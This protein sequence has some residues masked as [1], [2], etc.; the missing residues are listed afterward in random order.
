MNTVTNFEEQYLN[1]SKKDDCFLLDLEILQ[2]YGPNT[3]FI[4]AGLVNKYLEQ[5]NLGNLSDD[6][7]F[8]V[9]VNDLTTMTGIHETTQRKI[10]KTLMDLG[11]IDVDYRSRKRYIKINEDAVPK[12]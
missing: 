11:L 1:F 12:F 3:A 10:L 9:L 2:K 8:C 6:G 7:Y 4:L 5:K